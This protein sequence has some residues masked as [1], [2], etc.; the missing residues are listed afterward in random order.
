MRG[1]WMNEWVNEWLGSENVTRGMQQSGIGVVERGGGWG[2]GLM[3]EGIEAEVWN[4][5]IDFLPSFSFYCFY[6]VSCLS[7]S[8]SSQ[9]V[10]CFRSLSTPLLLPVVLYILTKP[11][12]QPPTFHTDILVYTYRNLVFPQPPLCVQAGMEPQ[13]KTGTP[14]NIWTEK[15]L[16]RN[17]AVKKSGTL[18]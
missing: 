11:L 16:R 7:P 15:P 2:G 3:E 6:C 8:R 17:R 18:F 13:L 14:E 10:L 5:H 4:A 12:I 1:E 9:S